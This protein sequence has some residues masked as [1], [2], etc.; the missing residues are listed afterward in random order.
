[1]GIV[2]QIV[3]TAISAAAFIAVVISLNQVNR[4]LKTNAVARI[5][6]EIHEIHHVFIEYPEIR[7]YFFHNEPL[8]SGNEYYLRCRGVAEMFFDVFEHIYQ[9]RGQ[10]FK[11]TDPHWKHYIEHMCDSSEFLCNYLDE[12]I[13]LVYP[14]DLRE[15]LRS[16]I[17]DL[18]MLKSSA[19]EQ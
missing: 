19:K 7:P 17:S 1:M 15:L 12:N 14:L 9:L 16:K 2:V 6:A 18:A 11:D 13:S 5:Y 8:A 10:A 3:S 4:S